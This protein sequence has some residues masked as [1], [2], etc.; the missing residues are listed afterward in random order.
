MSAILDK[1]LKG[2]KV[3]WQLFGEIAKIQRGASPR[4]ISQFI[5]EDENGIP[6]IRI[7]DTEVDSKYINSTAQKI[8]QEGGK[9]S[10]ILKK[11]DFI[12]S[13]SMSYG[14]PYILAIDGAIHDGWAS[15]TNFTSK[16]NPD[17]LYHYLLS[18]LVQNYWKS[19]INSGSVS[20]LN[21]DIIRTLPIPILPFEV[22]A[23][24]VRILDAFTAITAELTQELAKEKIL[25]EKQYQYYRD[26]LLSFSEAGIETDSNRQ[27]QTATDS[28]M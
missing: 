15:I 3:E 20:N 22:Q 4:P 27:Q 23:E 16:L 19:K 18:E 1:L 9:K 7:G 13:N 8:T 6:W 12:M 10:R 17:F 2:Q 25:R 14:R 11:G 26:K 28:I 5:T 24:I 21:A